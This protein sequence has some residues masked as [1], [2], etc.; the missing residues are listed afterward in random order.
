MLHIQASQVDFQI[1][2]VIPFEKYFTPINQFYD[3]AFFCDRVII[4][5][6]NLDCTKD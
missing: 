2:A 5:W 6:I 1:V 3:K 4:R